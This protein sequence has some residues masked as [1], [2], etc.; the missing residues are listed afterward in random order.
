MEVMEGMEGTNGMKG[1]EARA[2]SIECTFGPLPAVTAVANALPFRTT[3]PQTTLLDDGRPERS[4]PHDPVL[5]CARSRSTTRPFATAR[6]AK[7]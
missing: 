5:P 1:M 4:H 3:H 6:R 2:T 7:A